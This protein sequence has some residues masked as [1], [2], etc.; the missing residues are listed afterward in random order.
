M[1]I[2]ATF[3]KEAVDRFEPLLE[4]G[5]CYYFSGGKLKV[6]NS[7]YNTCKCSHEITFDQNSEIVAVPDESSGEI[8]QNIFEFKK[9]NEIELCEERSQVDVCAVV[10]SV[11]EVS[12]F[13]SK[14]SGKEVSGW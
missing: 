12:E 14:K 3:F 8:Q 1:D 4:E 6:A 11:G 13:V 5:G 7:Q 10:V 2:R 9:I